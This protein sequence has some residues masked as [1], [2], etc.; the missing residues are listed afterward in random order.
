[1]DRKPIFSAVTAAFKSVGLDNPF[2]DPGNVHALD[3][4]LDAWGFPV[5]P[6]PFDKEKFLT[7]LVNK[8]A[9]AIG[10]SDYEQAAALLRCSVAAVKAVAEVESRGSGFFPSGRPKILFERHW[11]HRLT[12]GKWSANYPIISGSAAGGYV[13]GEKEY[14]RL[15]LA[16][17][18]DKAAALKSASWGAFQIMGFNHEVCGYAD[19]DSMVE[20]MVASEGNHL[21]AFA[22][23]VKGN[24]LADELRRLDWAG[25]AKVYN[26][27][28]YKKNRYD[29][30]MAAAYERYSK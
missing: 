1:M 13:G 9:S 16:A 29:E 17:S 15:A 27:S 20:A 18:L 3:N 24:G 7:K 8:S 26:G 25:F 2:N 12:D 28:A 4:L 14:E 5:K 19:V 23:F 21:T 22:G 11:F 6:E 10:Q 30:K